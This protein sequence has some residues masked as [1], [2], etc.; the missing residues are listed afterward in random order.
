MT[1]EHIGVTPLATHVGAEISGV[2][3]A[4]PGAREVAEIRQALGEY[5]VVFFRDQRLT[6]EQHMPL[7]AA[8]ARSMST[9][10]LRRRRAIR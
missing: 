9:A 4:E 6:P 5:G 1:Y 3:L 8:L 2:D 10:S 7:R